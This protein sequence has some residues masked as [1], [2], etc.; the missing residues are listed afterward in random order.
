MTA[1]IP[2]EANG[3]YRN[4][5]T[6]HW[7]ER[8][9][10]VAGGVHVPKI[11]ICVDSLGR[12]HKQLFKGEGGDDLRQ[13]AVMEQVF[14]L[15]NIMLAQDRESKR[16]ELSIRTY[17]VIPLPHQTGLLQFVH[18]T[19]P[20][21]NWLVKA[22]SRYRS[23]DMPYL[24]TIGALKNVA[25]QKTLAAKIDRFLEIR[26]VFRPVLRH[27]FTESNKQ[28][29]VWYAKRLTYS[30]SVATCSIVGHILGLGDRHMSNL[31]MDA[32]SGE[33]IHIDLG[34]AFDQG[35][36]LP[37]PELVPFRLT[38]DV[39][40]GMG[41]AGTEGVYRKCSEQTLRV[42]REGSDII[43]TVLEVF[44][45]DPL[46]IW[47]ATPDKLRRIQDGAAESA[48][49]VVQPPSDSDQMLQGADRAI[50]SVSHK[51]D[52]TLSVEYTVNELINAAQN[53]AN[54]ARIFYGWSPQC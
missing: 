1:D 34:I 21:S 29:V 43:K 14:E 18:N 15:V 50:N 28:P 32:H 53:P 11:N 22:H 24:D 27:F 44:G 7:Y 25:A 30:R 51:L 6:I 3:E 4:I 42:L 54:L 19:V 13:D 12:Q 8:R 48:A 17:K 10:T 23:G 26:K 46:H 38:A 5:P 35:R 2:I 39:V 40:D 41:I 52:T 36:L 47:T 33:M 20:L 45:Y 37:I 9:Y 31:L 16:R 49:D